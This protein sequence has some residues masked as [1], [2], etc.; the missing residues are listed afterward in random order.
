MKQ[1]WLLFVFFT[2]T[3][4]GY[5]QFQKGDKLLGG[6]LNVETKREKKFF[7]MFTGAYGIHNTTTFVINPSFSLFTSSSFLHGLKLKLGYGK[8]RQISSSGSSATFPRKNVIHTGLGYFVRKYQPIA[9]KFGVFAEAGVEYYR[10]KYKFKGE[11]WATNQS[12][13]TKNAYGA[14]LVGGVYYRPNSKWMLSI[15][16]SF[17]SVLHTR[18]LQ[19]RIWD[20][21]AGV[22]ASQSLGVHYLL[23]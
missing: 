5:A 17:L 20:V 4:S 1:S 12:D 13:F 22:S 8:E 2:V 6:N 19:N 10:L 7:P 9:D 23:K 3:I 14:E 21:A 15:G 16:N 18:F 11:S